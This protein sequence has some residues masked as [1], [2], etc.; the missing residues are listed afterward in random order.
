MKACRIRFFPYTCI[1]RTREY[2]A[3]WCEVGSR[4]CWNPNSSLSVKFQSVWKLKWFGIRK[5]LKMSNGKFILIGW[6]LNFVFQ[7]HCW[8]CNIKNWNETILPT[9]GCKLQRLCIHTW[10]CLFYLLQCWRMI[11]WVFFC[12]HLKSGFIDLYCTA[13]CCF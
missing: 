6:R 2:A 5:C 4:L 12:T 9:S 13:I 11:L 1:L 8:F 3:N 7:L 10:V